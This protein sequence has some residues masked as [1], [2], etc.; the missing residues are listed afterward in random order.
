MTES[1]GYEEAVEATDYIGDKVTGANLEM[2][3][4]SVT[5]GS[6]LKSFTE[7]YTYPDNRLVIVTHDIPHFA[8][9]DRQAQGHAGQLIIAPIQD[10]SKETMAIWAGRIHFYQRLLQRIAQEY[11]RI[12]DPEVRKAAIVFYIAICKCLGVQDILTSNAV[13]SSDQTHKVGDIVRVSDHMMDPDD[14]FGVPEDERWFDD[15][16]AANPNYDYAR[17]DY[18]YSQAQLY[19]EEIYR[20]AE[21]IA[22]E[23]GWKLPQAVLNWR[24]GRGY[25]AVAYVKART[26]LGA[27]LFGMSAVPE[28]QKARSIGFNNQP[29][30]RHFAAF[31]L[32]SN[33]AQLDPE[34][35]L[36]H[37]E[38]SAA[39]NASEDRFN[40]FMHELIRRRI[41]QRAKKA[42]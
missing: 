4:I 42:A 21:K 40:P 27:S 19:S 36:S 22:Q 24:K 28:A 20:L 23:Q 33:V 6:G 32:V 7:R 39:G 34:Q 12:T 10:G 1:F 13:G 16:K 9:P 8:K 30:G 41:A 18:F 25:E 15:K 35:K 11:Q 14:D 17:D 31:S 5:L 38:V 29:D 26:K 2:P 37:G 3:Q